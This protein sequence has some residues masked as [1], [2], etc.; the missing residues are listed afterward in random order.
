ML[1]NRHQH[2]HRQNAAATPPLKVDNG[3]CHPW[4]TRRHPWRRGNRTLVS[5]TRQ[6]A[7]RLAPLGERPGQRLRGHGDGADRLVNAVR[8]VVAPS[9]ATLPLPSG[10]YRQGRQPGRHHPRPKISHNHRYS[11]RG[12]YAPAP[13]SMPSTSRPRQFTAQPAQKK[14]TRGAWCRSLPRRITIAM[15]PVQ[16]QRR[17]KGRAALNPVT[18]QDFNESVTAVPGT[19]PHEK[20]RVPSAFHPRAESPL[21]SIQSK[22]SAAPKHAPRQNHCDPSTAT[23]E[24]TNL[25]LYAR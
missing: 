25:L 2:D 21:Q 1:D 16:R 7:F 24:P 22:G 20:M 11:R 5:G 18:E 19:G 10:A 9:P 3:P 17:A 13:S 4:R 8:F 6:A 14:K 15:Y 23:T 12:G